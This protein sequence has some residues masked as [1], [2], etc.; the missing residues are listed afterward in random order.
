MVLTLAA[1]IA[2]SVIGTAHVHL[3]EATPTW[4]TVSLLDRL[5]PIRALAIS[6]GMFAAVIWVTVHVERAAHGR[7]LKARPLAAPLSQRLLHGPWPVLWGAV[8]L[9]LV[10][11]ATLVVA[12]RPWGV[13]SAFAL[14]GAK[15]ASVMGIDVASWPYWADTTRRAQLDASVF[16]D[17]TSVMNFG[18]VLGALAAAGLAGRFAPVW[19]ISGA[20]MAAAIVGGLLMGYGA[21]IAFGCNI[22]AYFSGIASTSLHGWLWGVCAFAGTILGTALRPWFTLSVE[23]TA[24]T[25]ASG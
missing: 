4:G 8:G 1:F 11:I 19:R 25:S 17:V 13:T 16:T 3:W 15:M 21:R 9:A 6:L 23:K 14:W 22:G 20:S 10:N 18:I 12:G 7:L 5:G 24:R 2:G